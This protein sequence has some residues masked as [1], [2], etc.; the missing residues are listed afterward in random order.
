[1][2]EAKLKA[3]YNDE[4]PRSRVVTVFMVASVLALVA[5]L[6]GLQAYYDRVKEQQVYIKQILPVSEDLRNLRAR[7]ESELHSY[8]YIDRAR[9]T[10]RL[11]IERAMELF[12]KEAAAGK[13]AYPMQPAPVKPIEPQGGTNA[14]AN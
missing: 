13:F 2:D 3:G 8:R 9:G 1:M 5:A 4:E 6:L 7:E 11:P 12:A 14:K 10:V